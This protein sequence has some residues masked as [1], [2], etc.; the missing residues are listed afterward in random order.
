LP[1]VES[2]HAGPTSADPLIAQEFYH[3]D[4]AAAHTTAPVEGDLTRRRVRVNA[5]TLAAENFEY[6]LYGNRTAAIDP[7]SNR[8][9]WT[10]DASLHLYPESETNALGQPRTTT[11]NF[12]CGLGAA[13]TDLNG[14][15]TVTTYDVFCRPTLV[16]RPSTGAFESF[17]YLNFGNAASQNVRT[18]RPHPN[19]GTIYHWQLFDGLG[20]IWRDQRSG[21]AAPVILVDRGFDARG[22]RA[23]ET[24]PF[25]AGA[26]SYATLFRYDGLKPPD[27]A[28]QPRRDDQELRAR[29]RYAD[30]RRRLGSACQDDHHRRAW[31]PVD[32][33]FRRL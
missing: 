2:T 19:S 26:T 13:E 14:L 29:H 22:N 11:W 30:K 23:S 16:N 31:P 5:T 18:G 24:H 21:P 20:R 17:A 10:F 9:E 7:L 27:P 4:G 33:R 15:Q 25:Y 1:A 6:D 3:Y 8:T 28:D 32:R 12:P